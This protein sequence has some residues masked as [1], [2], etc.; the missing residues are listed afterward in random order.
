MGSAELEL[1]WDPLGES[2]H[3]MIVTEQSLISKQPFHLGN[4]ISFRRK[5]ILSNKWMEHFQCD[6]WIKSV[7]DKGVEMPLTFHSLTTDSSRSTTSTTTTVPSL[8]QAQSDI[9]SL[10]VDPSYPPLPSGYRCKPSMATSNNLNTHLKT[11]SMESKISEDQ[12][13]DSKFSDPRATAWEIL[14]LSNSR[15]SSRN[16][17]LQLNSSLYGLR[18]DKD[19]RVSGCLGR[20][21]PRGY[22][23]RS[24]LFAS[25]VA[26]IKDIDGDVGCFMMMRAPGSTP[27]RKI[28]TEVQNEN[29]DDESQEN[30]GK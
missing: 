12:H 27:E 1:T 28:E 22:G 8:Q 2:C 17:S 3:E 16:S 21:I 29:G 25:P 15:V 20:S 13:P 30:E 7:N 11:Q 6:T 10:H 19:S 9:P 26:T 5:R 4:I 24:E 14:E 18:R 23:Q